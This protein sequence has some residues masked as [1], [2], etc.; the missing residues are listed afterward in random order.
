MVF[1]C[2]SLI[3]TLCYLV[4]II[5]LFVSSGMCDTNCSKVPIEALKPCEPI[6]TGASTKPSADCCLGVNLWDQ[7]N[8][9][10]SHTVCNC[11]KASPA[12]SF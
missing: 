8:R 9:R 10:F 4:I 2:R 3:S 7:S 5:S 11:Y 1:M 6:F 12:S